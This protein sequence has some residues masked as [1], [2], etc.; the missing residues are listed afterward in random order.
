MGSDSF[1]DDSLKS[2]FGSDDSCLAGYGLNVGNFGNG[3]EFWI[4]ILFFGNRNQS[5]FGL[6]VVVIGN[7]DV[8]I[9]G[10]NFV[11]NFLLQS[12]SDGNDHNHDD[13]PDGNGGNGNFYDGCGYAALEMF[14]SNESFGYE[15]F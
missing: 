15:I 5:Y 7:N 1:E 11:P 9:E 12:N 13:H 14:G 4:K 10:G 2:G 3:I 8:S 6:I